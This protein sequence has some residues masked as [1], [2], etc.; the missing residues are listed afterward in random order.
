MTEQLVATQA[1]AGKALL[2]LYV[3]DCEDRKLSQETIRRYASITKHYCDYLESMGLSP[4]RIDK[5][6][7]HDYIRK[8]ASENIDQKT[9]ENELTAISGLYEF[10]VFEDYM[11][12]NPVPGVR[13]RYI[14]RYKEEADADDEFPRQLISIEQMSLLIN[15]ILDTRD[16]A[17]NLLFAKTGVR[18]GE[19]IAMDLTDINWA[20]QSITLKRKQFKKR[21]N[22]TIFFDDETARILKR[23]T[24]QR[25]KL[26]SLTPA[27][28]IGEHGERLRR[29]G[30]YSL[31]IKYAARVGLHNSKSSHSEDHFSPHCFRHW[32]TTNLRRAGMDR[33][34][35]KSLRGDRRKD[36]IDVYDRI[37][38]EELRRA[39]LAFI[40]QLGV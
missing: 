21:S 37:D 12:N 1:P 20:E 5:H 33:E 31:V 27:L 8:R 17:I 36:A 9:M 2:E 29:N 23:W 18:R 34:F 6:V 26:D 19:L 16:K 15:S 7:L 24:H 28:F 10:L 14:R 11:S 3:R 4:F 32:Y 39:Y 30:V 22:R 13:K 40:P 38:P 25:S 35:I